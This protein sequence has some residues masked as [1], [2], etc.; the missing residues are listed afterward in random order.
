MAGK[1]RNGSVFMESNLAVLSELQLRQL[2]DSAVRVGGS[3]VYFLN[4][5]Q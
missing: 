2:Y 3:L 4:L 1:T 5:N